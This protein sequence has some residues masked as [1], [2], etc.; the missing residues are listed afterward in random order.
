MEKLS[1]DFYHVDSREQT[2]VIS[3]RSKYLY[4]LSH[5]VLH[6]NLV[7]TMV[8]VVHFSQSFS[9]LINVMSHSKIQQIHQSPILAL[10]SRLTLL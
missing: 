3:L 10:R 4:Q 5:L 6:Y 2:H 9:F 1:S 7:Y 8:I